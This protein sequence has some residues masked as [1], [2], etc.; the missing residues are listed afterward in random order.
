MLFKTKVSNCVSIDINS[1]LMTHVFLGK[2][3]TLDIAII[4]LKLYRS[5][6]MY[7]IMKCCLCFKNCIAQDGVHSRKS[8]KSWHRSATSSFV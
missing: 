4:S 6:C 3:V 2:T 5:I 1:F 7:N 8:E